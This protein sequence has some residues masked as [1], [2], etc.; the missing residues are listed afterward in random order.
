MSGI[1]P[2]CDTSAFWRRGVSQIITG[3][4]KE[5][6]REERLAE[7]GLKEVAAVLSLDDALRA[8]RVEVDGE[9]F[10]LLAELAIGAGLGG[11]AHG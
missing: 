4:E 1:E 5:T 11:E 9:T 7:L 6:E 3:L 10:H 2:R 8:A